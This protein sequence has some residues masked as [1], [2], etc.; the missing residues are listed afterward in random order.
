MPPDDCPEHAWQLAGVTLAEDVLVDYRCERCGA[1]AVAGSV[2][3]SDELRGLGAPRAAFMPPDE[4]PR[5]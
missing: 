3:G 2:A 4:T 1:V 5:A